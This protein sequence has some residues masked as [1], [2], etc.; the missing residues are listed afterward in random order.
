MNSH[1]KNLF[2][3]NNEINT[4][5]I[6]HLIK[7]STHADEKI[8][9][10]FSHILN[11]HHIWNS[12]ILKTKTHFEVFQIHSTENWKDIEKENSD[13]TFNIINLKRFEENINYSNSKGANYT[14][15]VGD[16]LFHI[17]NHSNYHRAQINS[18]LVNIG[19]QAL[20]T[21]YIFF[22]RS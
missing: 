17:I 21:D 2:K 10:L 11:A 22:K 19:E 18:H 15:N 13:I 16:I 4:L 9:K 5:L 1:F 3:Y 7:N 8:A 12:R 6:N 20:V 14:S